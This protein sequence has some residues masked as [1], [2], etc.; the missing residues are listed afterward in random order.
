MPG[1]DYRLRGTTELGGERHGRRVAVRFGGHEDA[2]RSEVEI[3]AP[4]NPFEAKSKRVE[5]RS[6]PEGL[7]MSRRKAAPNDWLYDLWVAE[8]L[9]AD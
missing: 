6:S 3:A 9:L 8:A 2:G 7:V 1:F 4:C 5:V